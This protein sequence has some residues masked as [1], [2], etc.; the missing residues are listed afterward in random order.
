MAKTLKILTIISFSI[1]PIGT[2]HLSIPLSL[3]LIAFVLQ[4]HILY[5]L[6][7]ISVMILL[8]N[9]FKKFAVKDFFVFLFCG[10]ILFIPI[11]TRH[12]YIIDKRKNANND[13]FYVTVGIFLFLYIITLLKLYHE[14]FK[15][16]I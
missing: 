1:I 9:T 13:S 5:I 6:P 3:N 14:N 15:K 7:I 8:I 4:G 11:L 10:L 2:G 12:L 16:L